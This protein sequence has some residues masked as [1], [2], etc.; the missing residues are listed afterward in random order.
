[1]PYIIKPRHP[2][3]RAYNTLYRALFDG[4]LPKDHHNCSG[5][6]IEDQEALNEAMD[7]LYKAKIARRLLTPH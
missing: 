6:D 1:M 5:V 7:D 3:Q 4:L 2:S